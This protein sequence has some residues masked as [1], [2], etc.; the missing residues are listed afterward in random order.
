MKLGALSNKARPRL[1]G[2]WQ[3]SVDDAAIRWLAIGGVAEAKI[4]DDLGV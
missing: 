2:T 3:K 4:P 1:R